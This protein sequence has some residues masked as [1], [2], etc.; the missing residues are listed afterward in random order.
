M[1]PP[2]FD[3]LRAE[4]LEEAVAAVQASGGEAKVLAGGQSLM[5]MLN[6]R[7]VRPSMLVDINHIPGLAF[8]EEGKDGLRVGALT[9]HHALEISPL[10]RKRFPIITAAMT[11]VAHLAIRNRGSIGGSLAHADPA[12]E[13]PM[14]SVLLDAKL[15]VRGV[16]GP[17]V[18]DARDFVLGA[19]STVLGE[20]DVLQEIEFPYLP[21][22]AGWGFEEVARRLGDFAIVAMGAIVV[23]AGN[24]VAEARIAIT[25]VGDTPMR[26]TE[27][28]QLL[29]GKV[30]GAQLID[31]AARAVQEAIEPSSDLHTSADY[32]RHLAGVLGRR[33]IE[34]AWLRAQGRGP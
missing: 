34:A 8:I 16:G 25:G 11:H 22:G 9:R 30:P 15:R 32:R 10:V 5:P 2:A 23:L 1:K 28:E 13:L 17:R 7:L 26:I 3:Y 12:A 6:F 18:I 24:E 21:P 14:L 20:A 27:A 19:M 29:L 33:V 31:A 4:S